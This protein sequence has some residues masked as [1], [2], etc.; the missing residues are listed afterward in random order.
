MID[1]TDYCMTVNH[2]SVAKFSHSNS[3][4]VNISES[5]SHQQDSDILHINVSF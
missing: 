4:H 5:K 2:A 3:E 1:T